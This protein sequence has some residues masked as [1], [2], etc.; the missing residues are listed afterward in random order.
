MKMIWVEDCI[1]DMAK[2]CS[3]VQDFYR[4]AGEVEEIIDV[5]SNNFMDRSV[6]VFEDGGVSMPTP[7]T[8]FNLI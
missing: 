5:V 3:D 8:W 6:I 2:S 4:N 1:V 7:N